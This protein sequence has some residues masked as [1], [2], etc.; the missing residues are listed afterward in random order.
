[1]ATTSPAHLIIDLSRTD[2]IDY[3]GIQ[4]AVNA[5]RH[6]RTLATIFGEVTVE[7]LA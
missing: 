1:M 2:F 5:M 3:A 4:L 7:R 6:I